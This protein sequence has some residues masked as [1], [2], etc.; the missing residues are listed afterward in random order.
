MYLGCVV[1]QGRVC[2]MCT[3]VQAIDDYALS[4]SKKALMTFLGFVGYYRCFCPNLSTIVVSPT[5]F[6]K[7]EVKYIWSSDYQKA[8]DVKDLICDALVLAAPRWDRAFT[9]R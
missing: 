8:I 6:L 3:M 5:H 7:S 1:V 2:P 9:W 4:L